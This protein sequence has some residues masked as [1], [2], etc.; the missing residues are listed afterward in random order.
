MLI[1]KMA[2]NI[3]LHDYLMRIMIV[4]Y[5]I[6]FTHLIEECRGQWLWQ[7]FPIHSFWFDKCMRHFQY[8]Y[9]YEGK[10]NFTCCHTCF[11]CVYVYVWG[12]LGK[13]GLVKDI[14]R[15]KSKRENFKF[16]RK[17]GNRYFQKE[18]KGWRQL[19]HHNLHLSYMHVVTKQNKCLQVFL[20]ACM[21][22]WWS[23]K[24]GIVSIKYNHS[25]LIWL[26]HS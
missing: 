14:I 19:L 18:E 7:V 24:R 5:H 26:R 15:K 12:K 4:S 9:I 13:K 10:T 20:C 23:R 11:V 17:R 3:A 8:C 2:A 1:R 25:I 21:F 22:H 6:A 16:Q